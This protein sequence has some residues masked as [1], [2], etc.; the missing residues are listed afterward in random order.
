M[1]LAEAMDTPVAFVFDGLA[2]ARDPSA[3]DRPPEDESQ[4][5]F[6]SARQAIDWVRLLADLAIRAR[7]ANFCVCSSP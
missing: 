3:E 5:A 1:A 7:G 2:R 4:R 6:G